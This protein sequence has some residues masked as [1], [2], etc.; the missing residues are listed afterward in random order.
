MT[1]LSRA[2]IPMEDISSLGQRLSEASYVA[3]IGRT[4]GSAATSKA[5]DNLLNLRTQC[6]NFQLGRVD[7]SALIHSFEAAENSVSGLFQETAGSRAGDVDG[8][9]TVLRQA[10]LALSDGAAEVPMLRG[11]ISSDELLREMG[12]GDLLVSMTEILRGVGCEDCRAEIAAVA[13]R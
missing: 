11:A 8:V 2:A 6:R 13:S 1:A 5:I 7:K 12:E 9:R 3:A 10:K 4:N